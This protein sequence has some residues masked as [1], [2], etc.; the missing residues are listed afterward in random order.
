M[1]KLKCRR[2]THNLT[3]KYILRPLIYRLSGVY[4]K[5]SACKGHHG[6]RCWDFASTITPHIFPHST[7]LFMT[8][9]PA[10]WPS[11]LAKSPSDLWNQSTPAEQKYLHMQVRSEG[12][13]MACV[14]FPLTCKHTNIL[15]GFSH[16]LPA[17]RSRSAWG[18][19]IA[20]FLMTA[21]AMRGEWQRE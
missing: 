19:E 21:A 10:H 5:A 14:P 13:H 6:E 2:R 9:P 20:F 4:H 3:Q 18:H 17:T 1:N 12:V 8:P 16:E 15:T 7:G 11:V